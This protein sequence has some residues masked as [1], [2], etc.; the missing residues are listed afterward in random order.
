MKLELDE[1][2]KEKESSA[3]LAV[4]TAARKLLPLLD[5]PP[6]QSSLPSDSSSSACS[7]SDEVSQLEALIRRQTSVIHD[8]ASSRLALQEQLATATRRLNELEEEKKRL[9]ERGKELER[10]VEERKVFIDAL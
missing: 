2:Q 5:E 3:A 9:E 1:L 6:L 7:S 10:E 4:A 8:Q